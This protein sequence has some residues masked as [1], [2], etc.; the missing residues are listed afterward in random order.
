MTKGIDYVYI[1]THCFAAAVEFWKAM[2]FEVVLD[3]GK[4]GRLVHP[5]DGGAVHLEEISKDRIPG[6]QMFL[7][8]DE[9]DTPEGVGVHADWH[10]SHWGTE[11]LEVKD[12]DGRV[13]VVQ[14]AGNR[15]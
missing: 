3:L 2:G 6:M 10:P 11:L 14:K 9:G 8:G 5:E 7:K 15:E 4:A 13:V 1:E 12:A